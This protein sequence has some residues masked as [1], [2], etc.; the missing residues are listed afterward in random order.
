MREPHDRRA[1]GDDLARLGLDRA[2]DAGSVGAQRRIV[3]GV[4]RQRGRTVRAH[5]RGAR[6]IG[7]GARLVEVGVRRPALL[8]E[9]RQPA[10]F[11]FRL[12]Q[13]GVGGGLFG[14]GLFELKTE[15]RLVEMRERFAAFTEGARIDEPGRHLAGT[16]KARSLSV[17]A[18]TTPERTCACSRGA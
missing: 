4:L 1:G 11:G 18:L 14:L 13:R 9:R 16:R 17:R 2:D 7:G 15:I 8:R 10:L 12:A 3:D 6:L 5:D